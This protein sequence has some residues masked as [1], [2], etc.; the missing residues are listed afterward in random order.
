MSLR[1]SLWK[2]PDGLVWRV[3][4]G[5]HESQRAARYR[6]FLD[7]ARPEPNDTILDVGVTDAAFL[8]ANYL[9]RAYPH[10]DRITALGVESLAKFA[11]AFPTVHVVQGDG[12]A[13]PFSDG[14][15]DIVYSNA[16]IEHVGSREDQMRFLAEMVRAARRCVFLATPNRW[17]PVDT[18]TMLPLVH[19]ANPTLRNWMYRKLGRQ[20]WASEDNL[21]LLSGHELRALAHRLPVSTY[22]VLSQHLLGMPSVLILFAQKL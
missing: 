2:W 18:H 13:L 9:E 7:L 10:R 6:L 3:T 16:V 4:R 5:V 12:R 21:N 22:S 11:A 8:S 15:F 19:W 1:N 20:Y 17:F 14:A